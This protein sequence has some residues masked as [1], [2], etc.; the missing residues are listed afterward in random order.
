MTEVL[1][2]RKRTADARVKKYRKAGAH[3]R[4]QKVI[5]YKVVKTK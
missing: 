4:V 5:R 2:K 1:H 3:V